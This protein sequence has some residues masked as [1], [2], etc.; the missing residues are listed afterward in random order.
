M[1]DLIEWMTSQHTDHALQE[2]FLA[3][4]KMWCQGEHHWTPAG[5]PVEVARA[6][7]PNWRNALLGRLHPQLEQVQQA[8]CS[9]KKTDNRWTV[10]LMK[11]LRGNHLENVVAAPK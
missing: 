6:S 8:S 2:L 11:K 4:L 1:E 3:N 9:Q 7:H 5:V 10:M